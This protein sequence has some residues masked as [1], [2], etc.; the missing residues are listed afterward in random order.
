MHVCV[1][2]T[3]GECVLCTTFQ[4]TGQTTTVTNH[5]ITTNAHKHSN[6]MC[7][8]MV[9]TYTQTITLYSVL[10]RNPHARFDES[11]LARAYIPAGLIEED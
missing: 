6:M 10:R 3:A 9:Y 5:E 11:V 7:Y 1:L 8:N 4:L 2:I